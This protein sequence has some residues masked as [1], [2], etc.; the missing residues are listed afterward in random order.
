METLSPLILRSGRR[1]LPCP[2]NNPFVPTT[3][4]IDFK[5]TIHAKLKAA[6]HTW[7]HQ[8]SRSHGKARADLVINYG[9]ETSSAQINLLVQHCTQK[10]QNKI[11]YSE[12]E[13]LQFVSRTYFLFQYMNMVKLP[14][15]N[16]TETRP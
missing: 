11:H 8:R 7:P 10:P 12:A 6:L 9:W 3:G 4:I 14:N 5:Q 16:Q 2:L 15:L 13:F 1:S